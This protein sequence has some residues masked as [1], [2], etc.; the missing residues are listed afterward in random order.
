MLTSVDGEIDLKSAVLSV[1]AAEWAVLR[2]PKVARAVV[3][4]AVVVRVVGCWV[5]IAVVAVVVVVLVAV[6]LV[7]AAVVAPDAVVLV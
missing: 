2:A 5:E 4:R 3:V 6:V 1:L 7:V